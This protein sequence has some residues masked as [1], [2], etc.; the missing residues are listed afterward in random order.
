MGEEGLLLGHEAGQNLELEVLSFRNC[1]YVPIAIVRVPLLP[2]QY[3]NFNIK[4]C[5]VVISFF[6]FFFG[7]SFLNIK[8]T[9]CTIYPFKVTSQ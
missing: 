6:F 3:P 8:F 2:N 9:Y 7:N 4:P 5:K 1:P